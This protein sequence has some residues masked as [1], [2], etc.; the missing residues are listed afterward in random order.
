M[1]ALLADGLR[2]LG[3]D[4]PPP[5]GGPASPYTNTWSYLKAHIPGASVLP[6]LTFNFGLAFYFGMTADGMVNL[7]AMTPPP[8]FTV[9]DRWWF[10]TLEA[11]RD[12]VTGLTALSAPPYAAYVSNSNHVTAPGNPFA[13]RV[14]R[15]RWYGE[16]CGGRVTGP[17]R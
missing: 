1:S 13:A 11:E 12:P 16:R 10:A 5:G 7:E 2:A 17:A 15:D 8:L 6:D 3:G 4:Q 9:D 14:F